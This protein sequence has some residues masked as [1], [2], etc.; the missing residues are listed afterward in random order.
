MLLQSKG[1]PYMISA[2]LVQISLILHVFAG[3]RDNHQKVIFLPLGMANSWSFRFMGAAELPDF[4]FRLTNFTLSLEL[5][6]KATM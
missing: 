6:T 2:K 3:F 5:H 1:V 4:L